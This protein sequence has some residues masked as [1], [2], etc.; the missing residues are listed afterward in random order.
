MKIN[1]YRDRHP[2]YMF[3]NT[4]QKVP[5]NKDSGIDWGNIGG[6]LLSIGGKM[7][8]AAV[9]VPG[10]NAFIDV[11]AGG[12]GKNQSIFATAPFVN[13][14]NKPFNLMPVP[15]P[16]FRTRKISLLGEEKFWTKMGKAPNIMGTRVDGLSASLRGS[17]KAGVLAGASATTGVYSLYN[18]D[19]YYGL[20]TQGAPALRN[21][22]TLKTMAGQSTTWKGSSFMDKARNIANKLQPF[23]GD[24]VNVIDYGKRNH[25]QIYRWLP[26]KELFGDAEGGVGKWL[27][28]QNTKIQKAT[29]FL[30][31]NPYGT[32]KDFIK[33]FF[34]GPK[35]HV[36]NK[37]AKDDI[38]VFRATM[39]SL[40]D[41]FSP[42]WSPINMIG[43]ADSNYHYSGYGRS[44]DLSFTV[45]ATSRDEMKFIYRKLNYLAGYTAPEY[46]NNSISLIAPWLRVTIGDLFVSTPAIINSLSYTF[47]DGDTTWEIN[48]EDDPEMKQVPHKISVSIGLDIITNELPEKGGAFYSLGDK[49]TYDANMQRKTGTDKHGNITPS[50]TE[51]D[52]LDDA[53]QSGISS[54]KKFFLNQEKQFLEFQDKETGKF[55][56]AKGQ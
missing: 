46:K 26:Q 33:F 4:N 23:R 31:A 42:S 44:V 17:V 8:A 25:H 45:Y 53:K 7:S 32:T 21:D 1:S 55:K 27:S 50:N 9:G 54:G 37:T 2:N 49:H 15:Y 51:K 48:L 40:S 39:T 20:G 14:N 34:T 12:V 11:A 10:V 24:K 43:R 29:K 18:V 28:K 5:Y 47:M 13:L 52:W 6:G 38:L 3:L 36:G 16:D 35:A 30:G 19:S 41:T 56:K 22:F